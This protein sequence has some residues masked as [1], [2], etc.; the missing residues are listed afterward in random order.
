MSFCK[1]SSEYIS[2]SYTTIDNLFFTRY[3]PSTP[4]ELCT[5]YLY[6]LYLCNNDG[7][8]YQSFDSFV[9]TLGISKDEVVHAFEYWQEQGLIKITSI[10]PLEI[11]YLPIKEINRATRKYAVGKYDDFTKAIQS[12]YTDRML[13]P[14]ELEEYFTLLEG[15]SLPDGR[16]ISQDALLAIVKY[17]VD[18]KGQQINYKYILTVARSWA[19]DGI[20]SLESVDEHIKQLSQTS[21]DMAN[22]ARALGA[23]R[24]TGVNEQQMYVKWTNDL[25]Y[26][27]SELVEIAKFHKGKSLEVFDNIIQNYYKLHLF[28]LKEIKSYEDNKQNLYNLARLVNKNIGVYYEQLESEVQTYIMP[29]LNLGFSPDCLNDISRQCF[30]KGFRTLRAMDEF[31]Q[32]LY[33]TGIVTQEAF[34]QYLQRN[35]AMDKEIL[36]MLDKC[37]LKRRVNN[38]DRDMYKRWL[39]AWN[40]PKDVILY[41]AK[42]SA[43]KTAPLMYLGKILAIWHEK[44]INTVE[45]AKKQNE[46]STSSSKSKSD[47]ATNLQQRDYTQSDWDNLF[48]NIKEIEI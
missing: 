12:I 20:I 26:Q 19:R 10:D 2:K 11:T 40:M 31:V 27:P 28:T 17:C 24:S 45:E 41:G 43:D 6:G 35:E 48:D 47:V 38:Q 18:N 13:S 37:G 25:G 9:D 32:K 15:F 16:K 34:N 4:P 36:E 23:K 42:L 46:V 3:L 30:K 5:I 1:F 29:W 7:S 22:V 33:S 44:G 8:D 14:N 21:E 39:I